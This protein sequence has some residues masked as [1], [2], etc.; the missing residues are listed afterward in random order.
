V[1]IYPLSELNTSV[2]RPRDYDALLFG[3]V[4]GRSLDLFAFWH[5]SQRN[6]PGLNLA[7]YASSKVDTYLSEARAT[8][9]ETKRNSLY[10]QFASA[11]QKDS[12]AVFL[13]APEFLYV[14]PKSLQ[15]V[16]LGALT[17]PSDRFLN[18]Y[19]WYSETESVWSVFV[20]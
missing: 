4:V 17:T 18:V 2:I 10:A 8:V 15:G 12:P 14:V 1:Q 5:S 11:L 16:E 20:R 19:Q 13:Y 7:M 3:E 6:D 9:D